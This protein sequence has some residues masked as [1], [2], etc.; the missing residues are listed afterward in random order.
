VAEAPELVPTGPEDSIG[1]VDTAGSKMI[2][3]GCTAN[4]TFKWKADDPASVPPGAGAVIKVKGPKIAGTYRRRVE[5]GTVTLKLAARV[6]R[7][8]AEWNG[9]LVTVAGKPVFPEIPTTHPFL[10]TACGPNAAPTPASSLPPGTPVQGA[11][12]VPGQPLP[13]GFKCK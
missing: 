4:L 8:S 11:P 3:N 9:T 5:S 2:T 1:F 12:C 7:R 10:N 6:N 13:P